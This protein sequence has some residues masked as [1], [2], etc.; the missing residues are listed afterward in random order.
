MDTALHIFHYAGCITLK[1]VMSLLGPFP[2]HCAWATQLISKKCC[3]GGKPFAALCPIWPAWDLNLWPPA[4]EVNSLRHLTMI[5]TTRWFRTNSNFSWR[6]S[7]T[8]TEKKL[9]NGQLLSECTFVQNAIVARERRIKM[10]QLI[11]FY[12]RGGIF[13]PLSFFYDKSLQKKE[14][15]LN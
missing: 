6:K 8:T 14:F 3:S 2:H 11:L 13:Q 5:I 15:S 12:T 1:H 10:H 9:E 4:P 7:Q